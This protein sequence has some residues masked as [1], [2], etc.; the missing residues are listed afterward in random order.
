MRGAGLGCC[1]V[2]VRLFAFCPASLVNLRVYTVETRATSHLIQGK[3][4]RS[5]WALAD[6]AREETNGTADE[7]TTSGKKDV[8]RQ[9]VLTHS[10][11]TVRD[12]ER[13]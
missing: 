4:V 5:R 1:E 11:G 13:L 12:R 8:G 7:A 3:F 9:K 2:A 10:A 6:V